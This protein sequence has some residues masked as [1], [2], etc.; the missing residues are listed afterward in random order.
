MN[1]L[2]RLAIS[3]V[4]IAM[5]CIG[6]AACVQRSDFAA[7]HKGQIAGSLAGAGVLLWLIGRVH[8]AREDEDEADAPQADAP[9]ASRRSSFLNFRY[10]GLMMVACGGIMAG[11]APMREVLSSPA[12]KV[13]VEAAE[14]LMRAKVPGRKSKANEAA[15][16]VPVLKMQ[17]IFHGHSRPSAIINGKT[18][19]VGDTI[20]N[21][22]IIAIES[23]SVTVE[24]GGATNIL[25]LKT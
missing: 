1:I 10:C 4:L 25:K 12:F 2:G 15:R 18:L 3:V 5:F 22:K 20:D 23:K 24:T 6:A 8:S 17:G 7:A 13:K 11:L 9:P 19:Y 21:T 16:S 14:R